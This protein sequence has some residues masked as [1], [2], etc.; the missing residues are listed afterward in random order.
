[1]VTP[2]FVLDS[3][4]HW[5]PRAVE[6]VMSVGGKIAGQPIDLQRLP[7]AEVR[8][9]F[10]PKMVDP[11]GPV[12]GYHRVEHDQHNPLY[13]HQYWLWYLYNPKAFLGTGNHEGD[14]EFVQL[15]CADA[16]GDV[17]VLVTASEHHTGGK[18]EIWRCELNGSR[19]PVIYVALGSHANY[20]N[21]FQ[22]L[23]DEADGKGVRL[24]EIEWREFG[25]WATWKGR[26]GNSTGPGQS[27]QSP[28]CQGDR[29][30][31]PY[32]YHSSSRG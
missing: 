14:W 7:D 30:I 19:Q 2:V 6:T 18:R 25:S 1:M 9:D 20:F 32:L 27:P 12:V 10:P 16:A 4:E 17:P 3:R 21:A 28:G 13:W 5:L 23:E 11:G 8:M 22:N 29:W 26:W 15:G 31:R 24:T